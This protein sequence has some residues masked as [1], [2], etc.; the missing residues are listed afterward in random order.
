MV[1]DSDAEAPVFQPLRTEFYGHG[2]SAT[3][4]RFF[5]LMPLRL[6]V[7]QDRS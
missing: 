1:R 2:K 3:L 7:T 4:A 6:N 5:G